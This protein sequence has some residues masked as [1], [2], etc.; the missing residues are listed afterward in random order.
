VRDVLPLYY[1]RLHLIHD[2]DDP[3]NPHLDHVETAV[4]DRYNEP[5][6]AVVLRPLQETAETL[7]ERFDDVEGSTWLRSGTRRDGARFTVDTFGRYLVH[8]PIHHVH[9][10]EENLARL[11]TQGDPSIY[12]YDSSTEET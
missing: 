4:T 12:F 1:V 11:A 5:D 10:V 3:A 2:H 7:A 8:D 6:P 9:D